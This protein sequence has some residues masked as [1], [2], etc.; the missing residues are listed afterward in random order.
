M[1]VERDVFQGYLTRNRLLPRR[2]GPREVTW[3]ARGRPD[4]PERVSGCRSGSACPFPPSPREARTRPAAALHTAAPA[5]PV[6]VIVIVL[7]CVVCC[8]SHLD[9]GLLEDSPRLPLRILSP[10]SAHSNTLNEHPLRG[11]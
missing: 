10:H 9:L 6:F 8:C 4:H 11:R 7:C 3:L 2:P 1:L 5:Q